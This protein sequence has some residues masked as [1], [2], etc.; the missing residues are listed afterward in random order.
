MLTKIDQRID[1][2][3]ARLTRKQAILLL[4]TLL[5]A[6]GGCAMFICSL[7][8]LSWV[9]STLIGIGVIAAICLFLLLRVIILTIIKVRHE[10]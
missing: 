1:V 3:I 8:Q 4:L 5:F 9:T 2:F 6:I 10:I 7:L